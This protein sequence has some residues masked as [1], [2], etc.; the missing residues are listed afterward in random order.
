MASDSVVCGFCLEKDKQLVDPRSLPCH[1]VHCY[2]CLVGDFEANRIVKCGTCKAVFDVTLVRLPPAMNREDSLQ[3]C[4]TCV[5][6]KTSGELA[7]SYCT[8]CNR[9]MCSKHLELHGQFFPLHRDVLD[10]KE[11]KNKAKMLEEHRCATHQDEPIVRGCSTCFQVLCMTC[12]DGTKG[13][14]GGSAHTTIKLEKLVNLLKDK[15]DE[16]KAEAWV[17]DGELSSL[18]KRSI[19]ILS[20]YENK[21]KELVDQ[22]HNSRDKQLSELRRMYDD[23]E[24]QLVENRR[25][26]KEQ[27]VEFIERDI[28]V[29]MTEMNTLLLLQDA[30]F[31]DSHQVDI[32]NS[33]TVTYNEIKRFID[34]DLPS[35]TLTNQRTLSAQ[36]KVQEPELQIV[37]DAAISTNLLTPPSLLKFKKVVPVPSAY[38]TVAYRDKF[39]YVGGVGAGLNRIDEL[40]SLVT[41][42][43][44]LEGNNING[45][46]FYNE[47][48]FILVHPFK[49]LVTDLNGK[50]ITS[51]DHSD[52]ISKPINKL[53]VTGDKLVVPNRSNNCMTVYSLDGQVI[54]HIPC[55]QDG[56][57]G[58]MALCAPDHKSVIVSSSATSTVF[59]VNIKTGETVWT[60]AEGDKPGGVACYEGDNILVTPLRSVYA[61]IRILQAETG[62]HLGRLIDSEKR[63]SS[64]VYDMCISGDTLIIPRY[65]EKKVLYS[66]LL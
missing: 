23:L 12:I 42:L 47:K 3:L 31:K 19:K 33:F 52:S 50:L 48:L 8:T 44:T 39:T 30:K 53:V 60:C 63:R 25:T 58:M 17:K 45:L 10:I 43:S 56:E 54:K 38:F 36:V 65:D 57:W 40:A 46:C 22:L 13:C 37:D 21:T 41:S 61:D 7:V 20:D 4:D 34:E 11:Y 6:N 27:L 49:V 66:Q 32:I 59:R 1:H 14:I 24:R 15:R 26:S 29:R 62:K 9:K 35:L 2:P 5:D 51:W 16:V 64:G 55:L 18:L 28:G